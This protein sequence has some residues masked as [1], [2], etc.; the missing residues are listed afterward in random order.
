MT[1]IRYGP[2]PFTFENGAAAAGVEVTVYAHGTST[3]IPL[4]TDDTG[5][6]PLANP[7][8]TD[9]AGLLSFYADPGF[10]DLAVNGVIFEIQLTGLPGGGGGS[11]VATLNQTTPSNSWIFAHALGLYPDIEVFV[12]GQRHYPSIDYA[13][14]TATITFPNATTGVAVARG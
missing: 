12:G 6:T 1:K 8:T 9:G 2:E 5:A 3:K 14:D 13:L 11:E 10:Y 4:Y 7:L